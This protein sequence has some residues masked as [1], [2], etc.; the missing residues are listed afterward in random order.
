MRRG[1]A[2]VISGVLALVAACTDGDDAQPAPTTQPEVPTTVVDR[3]GIALAGVAGSTTST[4]TERGTAV[5]TGSVQGPAGLLPGATVRIERLVA[6]REIRTDVL[7]GPDGRFVL[8]GVPGG[9]YRVRAF[10]APSYAQVIPEVRFLEDGEE[11]TF[12]LV[13]EEQSGLVV[14]ADVAPDTPLL[15]QPVNLVALVATR[16]VDGDGIVRYVPVVGATVELVGLG[17]WQLRDDSA[18]SAPSTSTSRP[19]GTTTTTARRTL[20]PQARTDGSGHVRF[21][22]RCTATGNPALA[23]QIPV[24]VTPAPDPSGAPVAPQPSTQ[25]VA[26]ELPACVD[27]ATTTTSAAPTTAPP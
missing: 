24:T 19:L 22:L 7:T 18:P 26:L 13:V 6:G 12:D 1:A 25:T 4:I 21:E 11:H 14:R 3:S 5:V 15:D 23:L 9:R 8:G 16:S 20:S 27:P 2:V 10:L 17:R